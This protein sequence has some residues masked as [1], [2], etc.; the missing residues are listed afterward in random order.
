MRM[1]EQ[2]F[3][4]YSERID[5]RLEKASVLAER[6]KSRKREKRLRKR[7]KLAQS[8]KTVQ[9]HESESDDDMPRLSGSKTSP[10]EL[11]AAAF[12]Q[13]RDQAA[14]NTSS[15]FIAEKTKRAPRTLARGQSSS[16]SIDDDVDDS[17]DSLLEEVTKGTKRREPKQRR[18][19][20]KKQA[21]QP[22]RNPQPN[23]VEEAST[24]SPSHKPLGHKA[25]RTK[26][27]AGSSG[28]TD[29]LGSKFAQAASAGATRRKSN[30]VEVA[31]ADRPSLDKTTTATTDSPAIE[32]WKPTKG[33][34]TPAAPKGA[35]PIRIVNQ[36]KTGRK[37]WNTTGTWFGTWK[38][39]YAAEKRGRIES[40]PDPSS[41]E[42]VNGTPEGLPINPLK[43][44]PHVEDNPYGRRETANRRM[45]DLSMDDD[46]TRGS[47]TI[48][49]LQPYEHAKIP[50]VCFDWH[51]RTCTFTPLQCRFL[52]RMRD[53]N[54]KPYK[55]S[56]WDGS[57]PAKYADP[58]QTCFFWLRSE[59]GCNKSAD[60]CTFSHDNT[61]WICRM[62]QLGHSV[63]RIDPE[64]R[65]KIAIVSKPET[66]Y[67]WFTS[68]RGCLK[69]AEECRFAHTNTGILKRAQGSGA[70]RIDPELLPVFMRNQRRPSVSTATA[71]NAIAVKPK[72]RSGELTC[73][74]WSEGKC[75][76]T[77]EECPFQH[78]YTGV[79]A[80]PPKS[81]SKRGKNMSVA[82]SSKVLTQE[83]D[84]LASQAPTESAI[85]KPGGE[86]SPHD[87]SIL[88]P[89]FDENDTVPSIPNPDSP[90]SSPI[91]TKPPSRQFSCAD[92]KQGI[93]N[94]CKLNFTEIFSYNYD[95]HSE[96]VLDRR[97]FVLFHPEDHMEELELITRWLL[98]HHVD[99]YS[100]WSDGAWH[101]FKEGIFKGE[102]GVIIAHPDFEYWAD[103]PDFG[104]VLRGK[105]R[106]WSVGLQNESAFDPQMSTSAPAMRYDRIEIFPHGGII[107]ITDDVFMKTPVEV[108][109][110]FELFFAKIEK[111]RQVA[112]PID[113]WKRV[114]DGCLLWRLA[115]RPELMQALFERCEA[116]EAEI[117]AKNPLHVSLLKLYEL[118][119]ATKY[120]EQDDAGPYCPRPDDY[121]PVISERF[122]VMENYYYP[123]L[124]TSQSLANT[125]MIE[126]FG[127][128]V[129]DQRQYYRQYFVVH[130]EPDGRDAKDWKERVQ[131]IDEVMSP[132]KFIEEF[133]KDARGNRFEFY[134][135]ASPTKKRVDSASNAD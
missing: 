57:V 93:E 63:E 112:G 121:F 41:L 34:K 48:S 76:N 74:F 8:E 98:M 132:A 73:F 29:G 82:V 7:K 91:Y 126:Y 40:T 127:G 22:E 103:I 6:A 106:L 36:P 24:V 131:N 110:I 72:M 50:L 9:P 17:E 117:E 96:A 37:A 23:N 79:V 102:T 2:K 97:A 28:N 113:P 16:D 122:P 129:I 88:Q 116:H 64:E 100:F 5:E 120:I 49:A 66:C 71:R 67:Y 86:V 95:Q 70:E 14:G 51:N 45:Q 11:R 99:V 101:R 59:R 33:H 3:A 21:D 128:I 15:L 133:E 35:N 26:F 10:K 47:E 78:Y 42:F 115:V 56:P 114:D 25:S 68:E 62:D 109:K 39:Q 53:D 80:D 58:P 119:A 90:H 135:W 104:E 12:T 77:P 92:L 134:D 52:H 69:P 19:S 55:F 38:S 125:R 87:E 61:G 89:N 107:Y 46:A 75:K 32:T 13:A 85:N 54:G 1:S 108:L 83:L 44:R 30:V 118:L 20:P 4:E 60:D 43:S 81:F 18:T 124:A 123:A 84:S 31:S 105:V 65:P 94:A 130:T 111:C 27:A